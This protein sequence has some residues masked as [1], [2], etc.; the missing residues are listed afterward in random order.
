[1]N[2][3]SPE[4][5]A[6]IHEQR[7]AV[8]YR[9]EMSAIYHARRERFLMACERACQAVAALSAT[10]AF[11]PL[12]SA[13]GQQP[14]LVL[15]I[16]TAIAS[17]LPLVYGFSAASHRHA[18]AAADYRRALADGHKGGE[19]WRED[20]LVKMKADLSEIEANEPAAYTALVVDCQ[21]QMAVAARQSERVVPLKWYQRLLMHVVDFHVEP[22]LSQHKQDGA[23][24]VV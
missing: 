10:A 24:A 14:G 2:A 18:Q 19:E 7:H 21:N 4:R 13:S 23:P 12:M 16:I 8:M 1:M 6:W 20:H 3:I 15:P 5:E 11:L 9:L 17:V 22:Q